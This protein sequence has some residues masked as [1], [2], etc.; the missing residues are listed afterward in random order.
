[1]TSSGGGRDPIPPTAQLWVWIYLPG[2]SHPV[3][4][5]RFDRTVTNTGRVGAFIYG[6]T[7]LARPD[8]LPIDPV[9]LPLQ[10]KRFATPFLSGWFSVLLDA[11]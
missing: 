9:A 11:G 6:S 4:C 3:L 10:A 8:R 1:M 7:Y 2:Q 5:G